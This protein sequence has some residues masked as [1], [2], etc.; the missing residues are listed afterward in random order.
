M[1]S[2]RV[3]VAE[4]DR[5]NRTIVCK[6]LQKFGAECSTAED[7][8]QAIE[9]ASQNE[10]DIIFLDFN[11]PVY[12]GQECAAFIREHS[13]KN[14]TKPPLIVGVS[15]DED[16]ESEELFDEFLPKPFKI[17]KVQEILA[18]TARED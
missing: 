17:E 1:G 5:L 12:N 4:D 11:M 14:S 6:L 2:I 16:Y 18:K 3:L 7:G 10:Y 13:E 8:R 15:A 9:K